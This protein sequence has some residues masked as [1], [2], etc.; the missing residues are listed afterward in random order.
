MA[1][2]ERWTGAE[3]QALRQAMRLSLR[4]FAAHL[5][6]A[7]RTVSKWEARGASIQ[8]RPDSEGILDTALSRTSDEVKTRFYQLLGGHS[9]N[10]NVLPEASA[11]S[12]D[13]VFVPVIVN[14]QPGFMPMAT[15]AVT[16]TD[17]AR[18]GAVAST[19]F[20]N[21]LVTA[22]EREDM[23]PLNRRQ[24]L[25]AG[26]TAAAVPALGLRADAWPAI[27]ATSTSSLPS[28]AHAGAAWAA[29]I[30]DSVLNPTDA[31]RQAAANG[32]QAMAT[33]TR[34]GVLRRNVDRAIADELSSD[35]ASLAQTL[36][37]LIGCAEAVGLDP[38]SGGEATAQGALID[39]YTVAAWTLIKADDPLAAWVA[40]Q[41]AI[42]VAEQAEDV[43]R[44]AA[45][46]R[47]LAEVYMRAKN[48]RDATRTAF[49]ATVH[50]DTVPAV[51]AATGCVRGAAL[52]S[53]AA[54][55][56]RSGDSREANTALKAA[57]VCA[58]DLGEDRA[59]FGTV[60]G[61]TNVA[62]HQ[63]AVAIEL[64][65][66]RRALEYVSAVR[67]DRM[68]PELTERRARFLIDVARCH[69]AVANHTAALDALLQ[70]ERIAPA[71][72][73]EHRLTQAL[74]RDLLTRERRSSNL[75]GLAE[76]CGQLN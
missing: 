55:A 53:A 27:A 65:D 72:L 51:R 59:D 69:A 32:D 26:L 6:V 54:A 2:V 22:T 16:D 70:A 13:A 43:L 30:T 61:P 31:I 48:F 44:M 21:P 71:E 75:R 35:Y 1:T 60:F 5:G 56:A 8:L 39:V 74:L 28:S 67:L 76:R 33:G 38:Q 23:R 63:V 41:R 7:I 17:V 25:R 11:E 36:P 64:G 40:A 15:S 37:N 18:I 42:Q 14:G 19:A 34:L 66:A 9:T 50:L 10:K 57:A 52:L 29:S 45:S 49:L 58:A 4:D 68:P 24:L 62:I 20:G 73:R 47:C 3:T 46:T 12:S